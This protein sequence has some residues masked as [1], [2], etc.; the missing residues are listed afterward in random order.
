MILP[1]SRR[2]RGG[3]VV[4]LG[5][6]AIF[7]LWMFRSVRLAEIPSESMQPTFEP[8]DVVVMRIDA[9]RERWPSRGEI[10]IFRDAEKGELLIKRVV[11][12]PGDEVFVSGSTVWVNKKLLSEPY[13]NGVH[14]S[15]RLHEATLAEDELWV[16]GDNRDSSSDSRDFGP[17]KK[18]Q[19]VGRAAAIIWPMARRERLVA[20]APAD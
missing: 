6:L 20:A 1:K 18:S 2:R 10:V 8:G 3:S 17:I 9:Y 11:A 4:F 15:R 14:L 13:A 12:L 5:L 19:L 7:T 16:M